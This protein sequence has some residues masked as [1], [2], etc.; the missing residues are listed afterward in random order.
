MTNTVCF[1]PLEQTN[2]EERFRMILFTARRPTTLLVMAFLLAVASIGCAGT[3][4]HSLFGKHPATPLNVCSFNIRYGTANDGDNHWS[5]RRDMVCKYIRDGR[6]DVIGLQEALKFQIDEILAAAP[7]YA[8]IGVGRDDGKEAGE[9]SAIL[10]RK[11]RLELLASD[12][13]WLSESPD[14]PGSRDWDAACTR[15]CTW[16]AFRDKV[17]GAQFVHYN[18]HFDHVSELARRNAARLIKEKMAMNA[19]AGPRILTGDFNAGETS[20]AIQTITAP[21]DDEDALPTL[22]DTFRVLYPNKQPAGT[23]NGF[24]GTNT[25]AKIDYVFVG[26]LSDDQIKDAVIDGYN[27]DGRY[28]SDHFPVYA[29]L[30]L[31]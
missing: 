11:D 20:D 4:G 23:F 7:Q 5:K 15:I 1:G 31:K 22:R 26:G 12:T 29:I 19:I 2:T 8:L 14:Q 13:F 28:P 27:E 18:T 17:T 9:Y 25:G 16:G 24:K 21:S 10:Y 6:M 3:S 30:E